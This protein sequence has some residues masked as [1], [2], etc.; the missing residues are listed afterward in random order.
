M[1]SWV[2]PTHAAGTSLLG[3]GTRSGR[4]TIAALIDYA[5]HLH[6]GYESQ[7]RAGFEA[8]CEANDFDLL[9]VVGRSLDL[10][11]HSRVYDLVHPDCA[12]GVIL[13]AQGLAAVC[14]PDGLQRFAERLAPLPLCSLGLELPGVPS[15]VSDD[16]PGIRDCVQHLV[17]HHHRRRL[18]FIAGPEHNLES[19]LRLS[20]YREALAE[21]GLRFD[22]DLVVHASLTPSS[23]ASATLSLLEREI[24]FD[25]IVAANDGMAL[26][27][28]DAL[29]ARGLPVPGDIAVTGFDDLAPSRFANPP[30]TTVRQPVEAM[31]AAAVDLLRRKLNG[32][33]VPLCTALPVRFLNRRSCGCDARRSFHAR[34]G[35]GDSP[36]R[37]NPFFWLQERLQP[38]TVRLEE[39]R[40][41]P[42]SANSW[43]PAVLQALD[44]ELQGQDGAFGA[45]IEELLKARRTQGA[46]YEELERALATL[47]EEFVSFRGGNE[48]DALWLDAERVVAAASASDQLQQ[49]MAAETAHWRMLRSGERLSTAFDLASLNAALAD[50]L[51]QV[52]QSAFISLFGSED[53]SGALTP[54]FCLDDGLPFAAEPQPFP[55]TS[56]APPA[57][58]KSARRRTLF[59]LPL[60]FEAETLGVAVIELNGV[61]IHEVLRAQISTALKSVALHHEIVEKTALHERSVQERLATARRMSS[62]SVLAGGV[63]HDLNN[64]LGP[65]VALPDIMLRDLREES[66]ELR[67]DL[68]TIKTAALRA[69]RTIK[70]LL[71]LGR[72][73]HTRREPLD[74][75]QLIESFLHGDPAA[76]NAEQSPGLSFRV[77]LH[78]EPLVVR[79]SEQQLSRALSNLLRNATEALEGCGQITLST[80]RVRLTE[81]LPAYETIEAGDYAAISVSDDGP[82]IAAPDR[83]RI[84][85]PFFTSK[86]LSDTSGSGLGLAIVHGVVKEHDG[87]IDVRT[88]L[89]AGTTFTL[90]FPLADE[91]PKQAVAKPSVSPSSARLLVV[92]DDPVQLRTA[93]R[94]LER[95]GYQV[96]T[97][98]GGRMA[99]KLFRDEERPS[100]SGRAFDLVLMDMI[101]NEAD[102][103]LAVFQHIREL[104]PEQ[105]GIVVSGHSPGDRARL[106]IQQ[107]LGWLAKPY[108]A[109]SLA[110][111]VEA[112]LK[113]QPPGAHAED[114]CA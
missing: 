70:D 112:M 22:P 11:P 14:G 52:T 94:V 82:G 96:T 39:T 36:T 71:A 79:V 76:P 59:V 20:T 43:V 98:L 8:A 46:V 90:Y 69:S 12:D 73:G 65:L 83:D 91:L 102:D 10:P 16:R 68:V 109:E 95:F 34:T 5:D 87:F 37:G 99:R 44:A 25:A 45:N 60:T 7:L 54:F 63:A 100:N 18:A 31:A 104:F 29:R 15:I 27:A 28:L 42:G 47:R 78:S 66:P 57:S 105:R 19:E 81:A 101:L 30:L 50:E 75:S 33:A 80:T 26:G 58:W 49:K 85:E 23:G 67:T 9:V 77:E 89:G 103:G 32:Q 110:Q 84:F 113:D 6:G 2:R 21:H 74:L 38:L 106:A 61:G 17:L 86:T 3:S 4:K 55:A 97:A 107:G 64:A 114:E 93:R 40:R 48:L 56:L 62:L 72:Q 108:T 92:D 41:L 51:P 88:E 1:V 53:G 13:V 111:M 24:P 35:K